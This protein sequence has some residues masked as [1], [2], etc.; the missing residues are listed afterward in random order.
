MQNA[1]FTLPGDTYYS[2]QEIWKCV[3]TLEK[4]ASNSGFFRELDFIFVY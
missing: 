3:T 1:K 2:I 4:Q